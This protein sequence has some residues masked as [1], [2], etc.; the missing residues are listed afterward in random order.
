MALLC[1]GRGY[2]DYDAYQGGRF[3]DALC[4]RVL[5]HYTGVVGGGSD[6]AVS[7]AL[8]GAEN[9]EGTFPILP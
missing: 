8:A 1:I 2:Q 4:L 6:G 9:E 3:G 7:L 5:S